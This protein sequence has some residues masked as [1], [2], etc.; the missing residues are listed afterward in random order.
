MRIKDIILDI[1]VESAIFE[2]AYR[3]KD[4]INQCR[5]LAYT[6]ILHL[7]KVFVFGKVNEYNHWLQELDNYFFK[8]EETILKGRNHTLS[9]EKMFQLL[10]DEPLGH[11]NNVDGYLKRVIKQ[12]KNYPVIQP[13]SQIIHNK[14]YKVLSDICVDI[15]KQDYKGIENYL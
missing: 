9:S 1:I 15:S 6:I 10:F 3:R 4:A 2:L 13:N 11:T 7:V 5:S 12:Y 14:I 8:L